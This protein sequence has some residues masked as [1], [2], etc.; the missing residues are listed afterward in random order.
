M[1]FVTSNRSVQ[2]HWCHHQSIPVVC[3]CPTTP[4]QRFCGWCYQVCQRSIKVHI[5]G[6]HRAFFSAIHPWPYAV[7]EGQSSI[8]KARNSSHLGFIY[9]VAFD[10]LAYLWGDD[11][12]CIARSSANSS[13]ALQDGAYNMVVGRKTVCQVAH[14]PSIVCNLCNT[15]TFTLFSPDNVTL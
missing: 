1:L 11:K 15:S 9:A 14:K 7:L 13:P 3:F 6:L 10:E 12:L 5:E 8:V 2:A 4:V